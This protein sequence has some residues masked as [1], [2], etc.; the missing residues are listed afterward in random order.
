MFSSMKIDDRLN[1][2]STKI[3][4]N[5]SVAPD[6]M[7]YYLAYLIDINHTDESHSKTSHRLFIDFQYQSI[8]KY[9]LIGIEY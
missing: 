5:R 9:Q 1:K 3:C 8:N 6:R 7:F 2:K 4:S